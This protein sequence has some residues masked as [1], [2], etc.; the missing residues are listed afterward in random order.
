MGS[1]AVMKDVSV[2]GHVWSDTARVSGSLIRIDGLRL[3][4]ALAR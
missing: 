3:G 1:K 4:F 2:D